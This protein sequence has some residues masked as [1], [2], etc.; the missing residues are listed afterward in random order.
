MKP[1]FTLLLFFLFIGVIQTQTIYDEIPAVAYDNFADCYNYTFWDDNFKTNISDPRKFSI[2]TSSFSLNVNYDDLNIQSLNIHSDNQTASVAFAAS[3]STIFPTEYS[4]N[5]DFAIL[6]NGLVIHEKSPTPTNFGNKDSQM[7]EYGTWLNRRFVSAEWTNGALV[8]PYFTGVEFTN[9]HNRLKMTLHVRPTVAIVNGQLQF[10]IEIPSVYSNQLNDGTIYAFA[11]TEDAGFAVKGGT[12][13][14]N[15]DLT[16]NTITVTTAAQDLVANT[17]YE[18]SIVLYAFK[19]NLSGTYTSLADEETEITIQTQQTL[20]NSNGTIMTTY[21]ADEGIHYLDIPRYGM[22]YNNCNQTEQLQNIEIALENTSDIA[23]RVRLCFRQI[24][25]VNVVGFNSLLRNN[26]GDPSG[27]P[28]QVSKNWHTTTSQLYSGSW[29]REYTEIIVPPQSTINF[30]YTRTG[31]K[32]GET[33]SASSHQLSVVGAGVPKGGWLEAALGSFGETITHSPDYLYGNSNICDYRPF[34]VTNEAY[35]GTSTECFWTG[36][37]GGM[38]M[39]V[40]TDD[41]NQRIYQS[42]VKTRFQRYSPNLTET[43]ISAYTSDHKLKLDYSFYLNRSDDYVR[44]YYKIKIKALED[45][46]FNRFDIFQMG[47]DIYNLHKAQTVYYGHV[48]GI[49]GQLVPTNDGSNDYTTT[50]IALSGEHPWIWAGDGKYTNG[51]GGLNIDTNNGMII[52]DYQ[53]AFGGMASNMPYFRERS[54]SQGFSSAS[55]ENPTSYC[56]VSPP[57]ITSFTA[58]DSVELVLETVILP[59][60]NGDYYGDNTN[61]AAALANH[62]NSVT[63]FLREAQ[64]NKITL[65]SSTNTV[66]N[67]YPYSVTTENNTALLNM[68]GGKSYVPLVFKGLTN[69]TDPVL[70]KS[71]DNCWEVVDQSTT[72]KD[73]WQADYQLETGLFDLVYNVNQDMV[74]DGT[75]NIGYYLGETP[76]TPSIVVQTLH[77]EEGWSL[78]PTVEVYLDDYAHFAPQVTENGVTTVGDGIWTWVGPN[79]FIGNVRNIQFTSITAADLGTYTVYY[80]ASYNCTTSQTFELLCAEEDT[81]GNCLTA[82]NSCSGFSPTPYD[83]SGTH[84]E[85]IDFKTMTYIESTASIDA[86]AEVNYVAGEYIL[87]HPEFHVP[88]GAVFHAYI[89]NCN[90]LENL[91]WDEHVG[92]SESNSKVLGDVRIYPNP[93]QEQ[94]RIDYVL[95]AATA[96]EVTISD[97]TGKYLA[98]LV[99]N[100]QQEAGEYGLDWSCGSRCSAGVLVL[101]IRTDEG[102]V[103][104]KMTM[105][106]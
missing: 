35:E 67:T 96:V 63:L 75:A 29:I 54:S 77:N 7:A 10:S 2:Q 103:A 95:S 48:E 44:V 102:V 82:D 6:Q 36:N 58:G 104:R 57:D 86:T 49:T 78:N 11:N 106:L 88:L 81:N 59:K 80:T 41:N 52:R 94:V 71:Q 24:P 18:V 20:P 99:K 90:A 85:N 73:F 27:F 91:T 97:L 22:G 92:T 61:F 70:W 76:P 37:V 69:I 3:K 47:G 39:W 84:A 101:H 60:L 1:T 42:E 66:N 45:A 55:G 62:G 72:G 19:N 33:Y 30:D 26:N 21:V 12:N 89:D 14:A 98:T 68:T 87:L 50:A 28:L 51:Y 105:G 23:K 65:N 56:L 79:G 4:G 64:G 32:W 8:E 40:Y 83:L 15:V 25:N 17:S 93:F 13:V 100:A 9:W 16:G 38:D 74:G 31:A 46:A 5:I 34:M 43:S 53:A